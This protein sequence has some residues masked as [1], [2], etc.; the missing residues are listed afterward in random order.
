MSQEIKLKTEEHLNKDNFEEW[1]FLTGNILKSKR[2]QKYVKKDKIGELKN[3][4]EEKSKIQTKD[5]QT[6]KEIND[7]K[8]EIENAETKDASTCT[9]IC[10]NV[11]KETLE[12]IKGLD[13]A[14]KIMEKLKSLYGKKKSSDVQ[15]WMRKMYSLKAKNL[16]D[17]KD[18]INQI[19]EIFDIMTKKQRK[20]RRLGKNSSF[21]LIF[22]KNLKGSNSS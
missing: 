14:Y 3:K 4:L 19:K 8:A 15:Y 17:C 9:I 7:L 21:I 10:T 1:E 2:L 13:T 11:S 20:S 18:V 12:F 22:P 5:E 16:S 6:L